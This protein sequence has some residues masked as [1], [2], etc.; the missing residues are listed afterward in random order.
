MN[1]LQIFLWSIV[2]L[3]GRNPFCS[4][5]KQTSKKDF[6]NQPGVDHGSEMA[7]TRSI[8]ILCF[9]RNRYHTEPFFASFN[10]KLRAIQTLDFR[11]YT[12]DL[13]I[14]GERKSPAVPTRYNSYYYTWLMNLV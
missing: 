4:S 8:N 10:H 5:P 14:L 3:A 6:T 7:G 9:D 12:S 13:S 11:R 1:L 2:W